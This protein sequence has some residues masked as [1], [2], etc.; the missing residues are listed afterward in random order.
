MGS[1]IFAALLEVLRLPNLAATAA[2][3]LFGLFI[4]S[5]P[6]LTIS[7]GMV[8]VL[9]LT[10]AMD[11]VTSI[12]L[13]LGLYTAGMTGGSFSAI[14]LNIPGT[15]SASATA[16]DGF[17]MTKQNRA[18]EALGTA[19][20]SS[21]TGGLI[22]LIC[23]VS[24]APLI[25]RVALKFGSAEL[26]ALVLLGL[27]MICSFSQKSRIKGLL[28]GI[29]GLIIMI[30]GLDPM[31]GTPRFTFGT[32][33]LQAG[34][35][36]LPAMIGLFAI[37]QIINNIR[38]C[39]S[40]TGECFDDEQKLGRILPGFR[41]FLKR[42][43]AILVGAILGTGIGA[44]P[45]AGGPIAV[46]LSQ[47]TAKKLKKCDD[48]ADGVAAP[49]AANNAVAGGALIPM[50]TLGIPGDPITAILL[51]ALTIHGLIPGP[52]LFENNAF[53][54]YC[55]FWA[56]L[57]ANV[58]NLVICLS[59]IKVWIKVL[60]VPQRILMPLIFILCI[61]GS[62]SLQN[63]FFD[64]GIMLFFGILAFFMRK[65][66]FPIVPLLLAIILGP[67][68]EEHLRMALII[69]QGSPSVFF[70]RPISLT[71]ILIAVVSFVVPIIRSLT[72]RER[73]GEGECAE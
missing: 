1:D 5:T 62:F 23:L 51:G 10:F 24:I 71:F 39:D 35:H 31:S 60:N 7:L 68:L 53:F 27:A 59:S 37:P 4:G 70:T 36:F 43:R 17:E 3:V 54:V 38:G 63:S 64:T 42:M 58:L 47:H 18:G 52:L 13:L 57:L 73:P 14:L 11:P 66:G 33:R 44:I 22:G 49:E 65:F 21:F 6:G 55:I 45:G 2:G 61:V 29:L 9:P 67:A 25:A 28:A 34:I 50:L 12:C 40:E 41:F 46:F 26:F 69:N 30:V 19:I 8:L 20:V 72:G 48:L 32:V 16:I 15:P 56:V